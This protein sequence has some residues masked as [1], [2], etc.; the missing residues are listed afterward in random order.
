MSKVTFAKTE[1]NEAGTVPA[2][3]FKNCTSL[4]AINI[5]NAKAVGDNAF[6]GCSALSEVIRDKDAEISIGNSAFEGTSS[7][8]DAEFNNVTSL[9]DYAFSHSSVKSVVYNGTAELGAGV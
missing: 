1:K 4:S 6:N 9:G 7:L 2:G 8:N 5:N 3:M